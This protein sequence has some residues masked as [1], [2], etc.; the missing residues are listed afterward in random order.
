MNSKES[1][2]RCFPG[3]TRRSALVGDARGEKVCGKPAHLKQV[4]TRGIHFSAQFG[5]VDV[6]ELAVPLADLTGN[7]HGV[8]VG[9]INR[10]HDSADGVAEREDTDA[11]RSHHDYV[12]LLSGRQRTDRA[13]ETCDSCAVHRHGFQNL[14][15]LD[16]C[17]CIRLAAVTASAH[18]RALQAKE[19]VHLSEEVAAK[20]GVEIGADSRL[21]AVIDRLL[22]SER[23][24]IKTKQGIRAR[25]DRYVYACIGK[26]LPDC[27][28]HAR[29]VI[30]D[31]VWP[32]DTLLSE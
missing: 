3:G 4:V 25:V 14:V 20:G 27:F 11:I 2:A 30:E 17:W 5:E 21:Q 8:D 28:W 12:G 13:F 19:R 22:I 7:H 24:V 1:A 29:A 10:L 26:E 16:R 9:A 6:D 23:F 31:V 18:D 32:E 15:H